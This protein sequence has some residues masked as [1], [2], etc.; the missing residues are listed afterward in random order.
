MVI[1]WRHCITTHFRPFQIS[2]YII[3]APHL[4]ISSGYNCPILSRWYCF[5]SIRPWWFDNGLK[6]DTCHRSL[7]SIYFDVDVYR[8]GECPSTGQLVVRQSYRCFYCITCALW[9]I[10]ELLSS[11]SQKY[12]NSEYC[13][14]II[15]L[16]MIARA[17]NSGYFGW[18]VFYVHIDICSRR[19]LWS[20][21]CTEYLHFTFLSFAV[22]DAGW[23]ILN[24]FY[25][26]SLFSRTKIFGE[27]SLSS[28]S[29]DVNWSP[30]CHIIRVRWLLSFTWLISK[31]LISTRGCILAYSEFAWR[32]Y[33]WSPWCPVYYFLVLFNEYYCMGGWVNGLIWLYIILYVI[34]QLIYCVCLRVRQ[35]GSAWL[36]LVRFTLV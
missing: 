5:Q 32:R 30:V 1:F 16:R 21:I 6:V 22:C 15:S 11:V 35:F 4:Y 13:D 36:S 23:A 7:T 18:H 8:T 27:M 9:R 14:I 12:T 31:S 3:T 17:S 20:V 26:L 34:L 24:L 25:R 10:L 28:H 29:V 2:S 19:I 33:T